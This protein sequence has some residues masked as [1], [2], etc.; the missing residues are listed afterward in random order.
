VEE[1]REQLRRGLTDLGCRVFPS[2]ANFLLVGPPPRAKLKGAE[3][4]EALLRQGIILRRLH[5]YG[6]PE[7]FRISVGNAEE[8]RVLLRALRELL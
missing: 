1:G 5:S 3:L 6:L 2:L 7:L 8:N 4:F